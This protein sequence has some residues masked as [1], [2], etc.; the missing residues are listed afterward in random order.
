LLL[1]SAAAVGIMLDTN[2][3]LLPIVNRHTCCDS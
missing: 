3:V 2:E 1:L